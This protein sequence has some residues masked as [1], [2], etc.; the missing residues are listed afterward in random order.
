VKRERERERKWEV[1]EGT[2]ET[3]I[4]SRVSSSNQVKEWLENNIKKAK[5]PGVP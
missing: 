1:R 4:H 3:L 5:S 2:K